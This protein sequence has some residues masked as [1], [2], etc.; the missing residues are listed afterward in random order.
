MASYVDIE[1]MGTRKSNSATAVPSESNGKTDK[2]SPYAL[3]SQ[4]R[5]EV[6]EWAFE[7]EEVIDGILTALLARKHVVQIGPPGCAKSFVTDLIASA[8]DGLNYF[9]VLL[10]EATPPE[11]ILGG[12][13]L[14]EWKDKDVFQRNFDKRLP[15]A[16]IANL[17]EMFNAP[18]PLLHTMHRIANERTFYNPEEVVCPLI[19]IVASAN[20]LPEKGEADAFF[21]RIHL[22]YSVGYLQDSLSKKKLMLNRATKPSI[23]VRLSLNDLES[24][25]QEV[26]QIEFP[27]LIADALIDLEIKLEQ[28][29]NITISDRR[30]NDIVDILR[31]YAYLMGDTSVSEEHLSIV[32]F[33]IW[34][35]P[36]QLPNINAIVSTVGS[37]V[38]A[39]ASEVIDAANSLIKGI[40]Q[41]PVDEIEAAR[42]QVSASGVSK[43]LNSM[44]GELNALLA[45]PQISA[46]STTKVKFAIKK[47]E[48]MRGDIF[49]KIKA[50]LQ[51]QS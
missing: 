27:E 41:C 44:L 40:G 32:P 8:F 16:H 37:P 34:N 45:N 12:I 18:A 35:R 19:T 38:A 46:S 20:K 23:K 33:C 39:K 47:I 42:W 7:R 49:E 22:R 50:Y 2:H 21:D 13:S 25:Q 10:H 28:E 43:Q 29:I 17:E 11:E 26:D 48:K 36:E 6:N 3:L 14:R 5:K 51:M 31:A 1:P 30:R 4:L 9:S 15:W 24:M